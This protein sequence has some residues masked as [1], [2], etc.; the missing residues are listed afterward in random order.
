MSDY[1]IN[2]GNVIKRAFGKLYNAS[3]K[4]FMKVYIK[5]GLLL[6]IK[7]LLF[8]LYFIATHYL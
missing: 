6:K 7:N 3:R 1:E 5:E 4:R 2:L 8:H